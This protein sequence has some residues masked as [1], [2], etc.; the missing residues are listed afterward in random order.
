MKVP[1]LVAGL[2]CAGGALATIITNTNANGTIMN[3]VYFA[4]GT[5]TPTK[6]KIDLCLHAMEADPPAAMHFCYMLTDTAPTAVKT[7]HEL[8]M[9]CQNAKCASLACAY[10]KEVRPAVS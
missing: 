8:P 2:W 7:G 10:F 3:V 5:V 4:E 6:C 1:A 9:K